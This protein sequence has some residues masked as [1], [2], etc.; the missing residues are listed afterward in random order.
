MK[1]AEDFFKYLE[2]QYDSKYKSKNQDKS[3][4]VKKIKENRYHLKYA[5]LLHDVG[6]A[7]L[8]HIGEKFFE[9]YI[10]DIKTKINELYMKKTG[11]IIDSF[12]MKKGN[13]HEWM[14]VLVIISNFFDMLNKIFSENKEDEMEHTNID[15][16]F[17]YLTRII[18]GNLYSDS[19]KLG[20]LNEEYWDKDIIIL[21][22]NSNT[23]DVDKLDYLMRDNFMF[24][25]IGPNIDI[26]RLL[27]SLVITDEG[28]LAFSGIGLSAIQSII[29]CRNN[30]FLW[31]INHHIVVYT[32]YILANCIEHL[33]NLYRF[34]NKNIAP[35]K[36]INSR[37]KIIVDNIEKIEKYYVKDD[38]NCD[39]LRIKDN[40]NTIEK[41]EC[42]M[43][44][45]EIKYLPYQEAINRDDYFSIKAILEKKVTDNDIYAKINEIK[46]LYKQNMAKDCVF[47]IYTQRIMNQ[48][49]NRDF[50]KPIWK[51]IYQ[52]NIFI[53]KIDIDKRQ[54]AITYLEDE[55]NRKKIVKIICKDTECKDSEIFL[56]DKR[57]TFYNK[58]KLSEIFIYLKEENN[59]KGKLHSIT[60]LLPSKNFDEMYDEI[61][62]Y[63][64]CQEVNKT[65]VEEKFF[66][67]MNEP[68]KIDALYNKHFLNSDY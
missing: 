63:L 13:W 64:Y 34:N 9:P 21:I 12:T 17:E 5:A 22:V 57:N 44:L 41:E 11:K 31:V 3:E 59:N 42:M 29:E 18:T 38:K 60:T 45:H 52:F 20:I 35:P 19:G 16:D 39:V 8:S 36:L 26:D 24:G 33:I 54:K 37:R 53:S 27:H 66:E 6:H 55:I 65:E 49:I 61:A 4:R 43:L 50:L 1:L 15:I 25:N 7:P 48:L 67:L 28:T 23:I 14:S 40:I 62:F 56:I 2:P 51:T 32:D 47:S 46:Y 10:V 58:A 30:L 68:H